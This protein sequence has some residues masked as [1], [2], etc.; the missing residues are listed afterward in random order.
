MT[1][2]K[3]NWRPY[4]EARKFARSLKLKNRSDWILYCKSSKI[5]KD[6]P[7]RPDVIYEEWISY[8]DFLGTKTISYKNHRFCTFL[9]TRDYVRKLHL[10]GNTEWRKF[11]ASKKRP[12]QLPVAPDQYYKKQGTWTNWSDF[13][14]TDNVASNEIIYRNFND[15]RI[16]AHSLKLKNSGEWRNFCK[17]SELPKDIPSNPDKTY[18]G[19][20]WTTWGDWLG[21]E[22]ISA[23]IRSQQ[24]LPPKEAKI[25]AR[26]IAKKLGITTRS[27]WTK[28]YKEGKIPKNLPGWLDG[29]YGKKK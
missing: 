4:M 10:S 27:G 23:R 13:L 7:K 24:F 29:F 9:E 1:G 11:A 26:K 16:F 12:I 21:T 17:S 20:G 25:E 14:G 22:N 6:I 8:P 15:A 5:P 28:A 19:K 2:Y 18:Q 3:H